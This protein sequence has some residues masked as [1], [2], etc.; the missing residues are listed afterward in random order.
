MHGE[1]RQRCWEVD[2]TSRFEDVLAAN[3]LAAFI[4]FTCQG[5]LLMQAG[6]EFGRTKLGEV[7][8][9]TL[10]IWWNIIRA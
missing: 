4:Y 2:F 8:W 3:R 6:E 9:R 7:R 1:L 10:E 5:N